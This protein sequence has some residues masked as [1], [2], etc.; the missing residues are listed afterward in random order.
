MAKVVEA[1][2]LGWK[3]GEWPAQ[4]ALD[5]QIWTRHAMV[6]GREHELEY[7]MYSTDSG[8]DLKVFND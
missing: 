7:A 1:S 8:L 6:F 5:G 2:D 4:F 3:P